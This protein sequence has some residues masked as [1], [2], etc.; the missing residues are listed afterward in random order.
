MLGTALG[1]SLADYCVETRELSQLD[2]CVTIYPL[3]LVFP[4]V[5]TVWWLSC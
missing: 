2:F 4:V 5:G 1:Q 3:R